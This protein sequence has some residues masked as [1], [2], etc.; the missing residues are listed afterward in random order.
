MS[1]GVVFLGDKTDHGGEV[2]SASANYTIDGKKVA[3]VGDMVSCPVDGHGTNPIVEGA[4]N[5]SVNGRAVVV[6]G[7]K[8]QCGCRVISS[9]TNCTVG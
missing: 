1:K 9:A 3:L 6:D 2:I 5:R 4:P 8:C 7:C